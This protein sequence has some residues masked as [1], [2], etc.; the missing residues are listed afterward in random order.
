MS[1]LISGLLFI[2]KNS[3]WIFCTNQRCIQD[4]LNGMLSMPTPTT[5]MGEPGLQGNNLILMNA[6]TYKVDTV[7]LPSI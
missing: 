3:W 5:G 2:K 4:N 7:D 6:I 1:L